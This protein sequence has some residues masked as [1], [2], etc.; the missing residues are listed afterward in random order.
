MHATTTFADT[1]AQIKAELTRLGCLF[2]PD[3]SR[4][5]DY[6]QRCHDGSF[7]VIEHASLPEGWVIMN[8]C[9]NVIAGSAL[10][11]LAALKATRAEDSW[12][13]AD[14]ENHDLAGWDAAMG[15]LSHDDN[16]Q[17]CAVQIG[18]DDIPTLIRPDTRYAKVTMIDR[19]T[20]EPF[21]RFRSPLRPGETTKELR[22]RVRP[23]LSCHCVNGKAVFEAL[24]DYDVMIELQA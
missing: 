17:F 6:D 23:F 18:E 10:D 22:G 11:V 13:F 19:C 24:P 16:P 7:E 8:W 21:Q 5:D 12:A 3:P 15:A 4:P 14:E 2:T 1:I 20:G 9:S